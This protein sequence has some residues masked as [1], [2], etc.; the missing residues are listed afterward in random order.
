MANATT[1]QAHTPAPW[2]YEEFK[3]DLDGSQP[4]LIRADDHNNVIATIDKFDP[5]TLDECKAN[6][7]PGRLRES[8][9]P[10]IIGETQ[11]SELLLA[12]NV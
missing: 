2:F 12:R 8:R 6:A 3:D 4:F 5:H 10:A 1:P 7:R 9:Q 11:I